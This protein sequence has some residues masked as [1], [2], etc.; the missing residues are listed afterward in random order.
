MA[1]LVSEVSVVIVRSLAS[2]RSCFILWLGPG[3]DWLQRGGRGGGD[4]MTV[5]TCMYLHVIFKAHC[6]FY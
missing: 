6:S 1:Y 5:Y 3:S 4:H 2:S